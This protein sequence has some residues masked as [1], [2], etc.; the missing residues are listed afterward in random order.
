[1][2]LLYSNKGLRIKLENINY[3]LVILSERNK[4]CM[5]TS[6]NIIVYLVY[7]SIRI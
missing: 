1:M 3:S 2:K 5:V 6:E 7:F 4:N